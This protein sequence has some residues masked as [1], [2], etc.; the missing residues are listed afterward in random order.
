MC[1]Y[2]EL[3]IIQWIDTFQKANVSCYKAMLYIPI[4]KSVQSTEQHILI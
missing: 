2:L 3:W 1:Q 4:I